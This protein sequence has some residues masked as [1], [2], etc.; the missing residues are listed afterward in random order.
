MA[1]NKEGHSLVERLRGSRALRW[2]LGVPV[3]LALLLYLASFFL[4]EPL[5]AM[6]ERRMNSHLVGY[7]VR[8]P[9][10]HLNPIGLSLTLK[11][12]AVLQQAHPET[13]IV[14]F[15]VLKASILWSEVLSG[16]LVAAFL[17]DSP[18]IN[19]NLQQLHS[20][21]ANKVPLKERGWQQAVEEIYPLKINTL[22]INDATVTYI[23][24]DP[25]RPLV[26]SHLNLQATNIRNIHSPGQVYPSSFHLDTAIFGTGSGTIDGNANFLDQPFPGIKGR[27][28]LVGVP[29]DNLKPLMTGGNFTLQGGVLGATGAAEYAP[30]IKVAHL[31]KLTVQGM[32]ADY[33][34]AKS[35]AVVEKKRAVAV[36]KTAK[37]LA[38]E[39]GLL[40]RADQVSLTR[41]NLGLVN[42]AGPKPYRLFISDADFELKNFSNQFSQGPAQA[43]LTGK[44]MGS[45]STVATMNF[46]PPKA[47][48]D[49]DLQL[50]VED[51]QM[52]ALNDLLR[53]YGHFD[54]SAGVFSLVTELHIKDETLSGYIKP[55][56]RDMQVYDARKDQGKTL[57]HKAYEILVGGAAKLLQN[58][59]RQEVATK[60]DIRGSLNKPQTSR[61]QIVGELF[62]NAF[63]RAILPGFEKKPSAKR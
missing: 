60:V 23:N 26:L 28:K 51:T 9:G 58:R 35:T 62:R 43:R 36:G 2:G 61:W 8:L 46:R 30:R 27:V 22:K 52:T 29:V 14:R 39:P 56:F 31:E 33:I 18:N 49:L 41:C 40:I 48:P 63:F 37:K 21:A 42:N 15:P 12:L 17:L 55:F 24:R 34:H 38:N 5:R 54:V 25:K 13:P 11:G 59:P 6:M 10:L 1:E 44:F 45:G 57:M 7:T 4:D 3:A 32:R 16:K 50:K 19:I 20:E 53:A 47:G